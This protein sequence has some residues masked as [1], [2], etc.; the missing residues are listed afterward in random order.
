MPLMEAQGRAQEEAA[1]LLGA[2]FAT[3]FFRVTFPDIIWAVLAGV[4]LCTA[5]AFGEFGAVSVVSGHIPGVTETMPLHIESLYDD[6][7]S[8]AAF[9]MAACLGMFALVTLVAKA[10]VE[11]RARRQAGRWRMTVSVIG[12]TQRYGNTPS[13]HD[14]NLEVRPGEFLAVVG[15]SGAG[16]TTLLRLIAGLG[17]AVQRN[18][19]DRRTRHGR[20]S[21]E[22]AEHRL[23]FSELC[24]V[25]AHD[26][27]GERGFRPARAAADGKACDHQPVAEL[28]ELM[29]ILQLAGRRPGQLSGG[30][31][32]RVALARALATSPELMLMDEPFGALDPLVRKDIRNWLRGLHTQLGLTSI[33]IT[34]DQGEA[35][36]LAD[37][38]AV[39]R[40]GRILQIGTPDE[41][42]ENPAAPFVFEFLGPTIRLEGVIRGG[43]FHASDLPVQPFHRA[44]ADGLGRGAVAPT[45][46]GADPEW[47]RGGSGVCQEGG[48]AR[49]SHGRMP[50]PHDGAGIDRRGAAAWL[51]LQPGHV[52]GDHLLS[53]AN[54]GACAG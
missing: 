11:W 23:R 44:G 10:L 15:P 30:Q 8:A 52:G 40:G 50:R 7:Q 16:K 33:F 26:G 1:A 20:G 42:E 6:Y 12:V 5:R 14:V 25:P 35:V 13:L 31:Q 22:A 41:L 4:L 51:P 2:G 49:A 17:D 9:A 27:G 53:V 21:G 38:V 47:R 18:A 3:T 48:A 43:A 24:A 32:Q 54:P 36:E 34:H 19:A 37:R 45:P 39:M 28:L 29:Q 46:T